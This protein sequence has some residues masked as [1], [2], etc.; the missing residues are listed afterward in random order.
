MIMLH[1][2]TVVAVSNPFDFFIVLFIQP[3]L[4]EAVWMFCVGLHAGRLFMITGNINMC[5]NCSDGA[6]RSFICCVSIIFS[7]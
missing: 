1:H 4:K 6:S 3:L 5:C 2:L 7:L